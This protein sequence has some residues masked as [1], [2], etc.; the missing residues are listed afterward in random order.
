MELSFI[1]PVYNVEAYITECLEPLTRIRGIKFEVIIVDD[2]S[3]D[4]SIA[5]AKTFSNKLPLKIIHQENKGLSGARNAGLQAATGEYIYFYDSD[6]LIIPHEFMKLFKKTQENNLDVCSGKGMIF[7]EVSTLTPIKKDEALKLTG[8]LSGPA[9]Y[10]LMEKKSE[11]SPMVWLRIYRREFLSQHQLKFTEEIIHEDEEFTALCFAYAKRCAYFPLDFYRYRFREGS[12]SKSVRHKYLNP[13][14][15]PS[16]SRMAVN[17]S[18][19]ITGDN[20]SKD[21]FSNAISKC[22]VEILRRLEYQKQVQMIKKIPGWAE[23]NLTK[24]LK[25]LPLKN[26]LQV[27]RYKFKL[28]F[29]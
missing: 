3:P 25:A 19:T 17:L 6:D 13:N 4:N 29:K 15:I 16:F 26:R 10:A 2:G 14:S 21:V 11:Y 8:I 18:Q 22:L 23:L 12:I 7:S 20:E 9:M 5:T 1:I 24:V 28:F 27:Y